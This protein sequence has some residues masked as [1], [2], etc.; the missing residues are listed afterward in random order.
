[1]ALRKWNGQDLGWIIQD[2]ENEV[3]SQDIAKFPG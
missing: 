2:G 1:M 3:Q